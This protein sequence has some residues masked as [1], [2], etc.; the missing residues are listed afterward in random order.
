MLWF[1]GPCSS[2]VVLTTSLRGYCRNSSGYFNFVN[3][4][5]STALRL[6]TGLGSSE[7]QP[8][9]SRF[10]TEPK[11]VLIETLKRCPVLSSNMTVDKMFVLC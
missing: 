7:V 2:I 8:Q 6:I 3:S 9:L 10:N 11:Q 4:V 1:G 5:E